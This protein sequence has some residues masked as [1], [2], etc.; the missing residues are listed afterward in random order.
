M[1]K[2]K[3][4][5]INM[6]KKGYTDWVF[7][8]L[9]NKAQPSEYYGGVEQA[10]VFFFGNCGSFIFISDNMFHQISPTEKPFDKSKNAENTLT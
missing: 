2:A 6:T 9:K 5:A 8:R 10:Q 4:L 3:K 1:K 7:E